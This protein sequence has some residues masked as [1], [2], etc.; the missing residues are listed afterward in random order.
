MQKPV[1]LLIGNH[2]LSANLNKN[3]WHFMAERLAGRGWEVITTSDKRFPPLRL[4]DMVWTV[5]QERRRYDLAQIDVFS[6]KAFIWSEVCTFFLKR[7][8]KPILL[9]LHGGKLPEFAAEHPQRVRRVMQSADVIVTPSPY[10]QVAFEKYRPDIRLILNPINLEKSI[11]RHRLQAQPRLV[12]VRAFHEVY[13]PCLAPRV[14]HLLAPD[15]QEIE[16]LM[17]GPD[18]GDGSLERMLNLAEQLGLR[19]RIR[20]AGGIPHEQVPIYLDKGDVFINTTN[21]DTAPRSVLEAMANGLCVVTTNVGGMPWLVEEEVD[22]L[23]VP[24][25]DPG[26]MAAAVSRVLTDPGLSARLSANARHKAEAYDWSAIL[27]QW[28]RLF[29]EVSNPSKFTPNNSA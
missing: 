11:Y 5:I 7:L 12:W 15:F 2:F 8:G 3:I 9:T 22:G 19:D 26:A 20:I 28:E 6:E 24:P 18:K 23:L 27:P 21:Y 10:H 16:L 13:N 4:L 25:D 29:L 17:I 14:L 1:L